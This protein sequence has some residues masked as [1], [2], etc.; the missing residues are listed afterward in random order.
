MYTNSKMISNI[1]VY[2]KNEVPL[3]YNYRNNRR[4]API[5]VVAREGYRLVVSNLH[6]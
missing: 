2:W 5:V 3:E 1:D 6:S 4:I